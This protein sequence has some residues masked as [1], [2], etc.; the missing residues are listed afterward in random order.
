MQGSIIDVPFIPED[1]LLDIYT[2]AP[3]V[4][5]LVDNIKDNIGMTE[6]KTLF[7]INP[8]GLIRKLS[9]KPDPE[10]KARVIAIGDYWSQC[11]LKP[12]HERIF[13]ILHEVTG[14][15]TFTQTSPFRT[16]PKSGPYYS[17]DLSSATDRFPLKF[18]IRVVAILTGSEEYAEAW[19]RIM[20]KYLFDYQGES[21]AYAC[22][23]PMGLYSS[24]AVF[25][26]S[27][28]VL[29]RIAS[30]RTNHG[31]GW[32]KYALL[33]DDIVLTNGKVAS[34]YRELIQMLGV[35][36]ALN[37]SHTSNNMCEFAKR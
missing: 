16:L 17:L 2:I 27:H 21:H 15:R 10:G 20:T 34:K 11:A 37:K 7:S 24:W 19:G 8:K 12:L 3:E 36:I 22:G 18:Q 4:K 14:D 25:S 23:Q 31:F 30:S 26:L 5:P 9:I 28:H 13:S 1:L 29:V 35:D 6:Y 32:T 33:G